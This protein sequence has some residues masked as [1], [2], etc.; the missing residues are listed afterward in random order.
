MYRTNPLEIPHREREYTRVVIST[1][2]K[3]HVTGSHGV[4]IANECYD[5]LDYAQIRMD[6]I[7]NLM[8]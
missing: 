7:L 5:Y 4:A 8:R 1:R 6:D 3:L 2:S